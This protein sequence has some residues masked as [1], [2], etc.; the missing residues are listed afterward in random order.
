MSEAEGAARSLRVHVAAA[1]GGICLTGLRGTVRARS[2]NGTVRA[3]D[4][5]GD[6]EIHTSN[7][8]VHTKCTCGRLVARSSNGKIELSEHRGSVDAATSNG[9][10]SC[11]IEGMGKDGV[12]L[13]TS[14]G[15]I[16]LEL[17]EEVDCDVD[18]R[19]DNGVIRTSREIPD[20]TGERSG[21]LKGT[22]GRGG[23]PVRLR[24]SNG[25]ISLR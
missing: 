4:V 1:N 2:S 16:T 11:E 8:K 13:V 19:V 14:N 6:L 17:P 24:A 7:A 10:I 15:R 9:S 20:S 5:V 12:M 23:V 22:L 18:L 25:T 3:S 21:R